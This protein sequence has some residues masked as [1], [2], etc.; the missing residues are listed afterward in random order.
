M[1]SAVSNPPDYTEFGDELEQYFIRHF[2]NKRTH[3]LAV[4]LRQPGGF[5]YLRTNTLRISTENLITQLRKENVS[6]AIGDDELGAVAIPIQPSGPVTQYEKIVV[7]DKASS[8]NILLGSHLY[9]PGVLRSDR[10]FKDENITIVNPRGHIVGSGIAEIDSSQLPT[11]KRG[12]VVRLTDCLYTLPSLVDLK[13]Y[14]RGYFYSQSLS[15]MLVAPILNPQKDE[16]IIDFCAAPGGKSTHIAQ[17]VNNQCHLIAV[18]RSK[19]R[20]ARLQTEA[21][22]L[23]ITCIRSFIGRAH[24]FVKEHPAIL[25]DRVL[26]DPPCTALGVRPKLYDE[27][28]MARIQSTASYQRMILDSASTALRPG[29]VLVYST[30]T[31]TVEENEHNIYHLV[32]E[33]G[34]DLEKQIPYR[35]TEGL[36]GSGLLKQHVQRIYPDIHDLPGYFIARLRKSES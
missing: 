31:L 5:F 14:Q 32:N 23:G 25:A 8:E 4:A 15:A 17:L 24:E 12:L 36:I 3:Q 19:R 11:M 6:A 22:R 1:I 16:T 26:V 35:G 20:I 10:F 33:K 18:D 28:T 30:C 9:R 34:Y 27:T 21:N 7:A 29:G 2:G 13:A